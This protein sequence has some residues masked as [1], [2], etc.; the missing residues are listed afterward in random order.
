[1]KIGFLTTANS[2]HIPVKTKYF[3]EQGHE[4]YYIEIHPGTGQQIVPDGVVCYSIKSKWPSFLGYINKLWKAYCYSKTI[5]L[6]ILQ[7]I[8]MKYSPYAIIFKAKKI[9]IENTGSDVLLFP[10][11]YKW[12]KYVYKLLYSKANAVIQDSL[13]TQNAGIK[14]GAPK[15]FNKI[16][17]LGIDFKVFNKDVPKGNARKRLMLGNEKIIFSPRG[18]TDLYNIE[19]IIKSIPFVMDSFP[20]VKFVFCR[21]FGKKEDEF[22]DLIKRLSVSSNVVFTGFLDNEKDMPLFYT[23]SDIV[24]SVPSSDSSP[25]S[26][27]EAMACLTPVIISELPWYHQ[28]F[29]RDINVCVVPI[30]DEIKL[31]EKIVKILNGEIVIDIESAYQYVESNINMISHSKEAEKLY[32]NLLAN[33]RN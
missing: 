25:R 22:A 21:H 13:V 20:D 16:V 8:S 1:M 6:D 10:N 24:V 27:Y 12:L 30:K 32:L 15:K 26:V 14:C 28:K 29:Q 19:T 3:V 31:A 5:G 2:W 33:I 7:I 23:D 11:K 4:V 9:V 17:E 18:F